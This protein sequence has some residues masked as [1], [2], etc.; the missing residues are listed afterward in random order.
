M[1]Y[2]VVRNEDGFEELVFEGT[3]EDAEY[4]KS[5]LESRLSL[6]EDEGRSGWRRVKYYLFPETEWKMEIGTMH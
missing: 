2:Y 1:I 4:E 3:R 6:S 5:L